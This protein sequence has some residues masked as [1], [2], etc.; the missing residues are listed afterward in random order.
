MILLNPSMLQHGMH[1]VPPFKKQKHTTLLPLSHV[2]PAIIARFLAFATGPFTPI[3]RMTKAQYRSA[4][5]QTLIEIGASNTTHSAR[6]IFASIQF[7]LTHQLT[8][9]QRH[10]I[11][12]VPKTT[13]TYIHE[14][15]ESERSVI[16]AN[17]LL[18]MP[19]QL[20]Q[21]APLPTLRVTT[22]PLLE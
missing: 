6:H 2:N 11:H 8:T 15:P 4:F 22:R 9:V 14:L 20:P 10:L 16:L 7:F 21:L 1:V 5:K 12:Q 13:L 3:L 19:I 18:F 17:P